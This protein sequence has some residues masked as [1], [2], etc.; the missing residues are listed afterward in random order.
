MTSYVYDVMTHRMMSDDGIVVKLRHI[1]GYNLAL[2]MI[3]ALNCVA[4][5]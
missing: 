5:Y 4:K 2:T 3:V 1:G